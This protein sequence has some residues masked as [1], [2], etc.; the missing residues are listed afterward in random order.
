MKNKALFTCIRNDWNT[1]K[2]LYK[3]LDKEF[4]FDFDPCPNK[5]DFDGLEIEWGFSN[6]VNPPYKTD[7]QNKFIKKGFEEFKKGKT[8]VFLIPARTDT[9]R[10][11]DIIFPNASEIRFLRGRLKFDD[12]GGTAT[13]PSAI[14]VFKNG[15]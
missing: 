1:P 14:I 8:V 2:E 11:Q 10:W 13:F 9:K 4:K 5:P 7:I 12:G 3:Q 6:F 15:K